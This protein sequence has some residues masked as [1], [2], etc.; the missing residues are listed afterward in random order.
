MK[1][2]PLTAGIEKDED[3]YVASC[4]ELGVASQGRSIKEAETM[5]KE[6]VEL[7]LEEAAPEEIKRR[8][9]CG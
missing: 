5:I 7:L 9:H 4:P 8:I 2:P 3:W 6:A 1:L